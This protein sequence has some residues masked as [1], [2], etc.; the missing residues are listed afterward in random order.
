MEE[1]YGLPEFLKKMT[2]IVNERFER[3]ESAIKEMEAKI[4]KNE[5]E[6]SEIRSAMQNIK[7]TLQSMK[8]EGVDKS[9]LKI[10]EG[11]TEKS[12]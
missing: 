7:D 9:L 8:V 4:I 2:I 12:F 5:N 3:C 1:R 11:R 10:L 6:M